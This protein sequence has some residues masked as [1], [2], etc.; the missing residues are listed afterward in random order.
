MSLTTLVKLYRNIINYLLCSS[1][2]QLSGLLKLL[3]VNFLYSD[4]PTKYHDTI[5]NIL[6]APV[7]DGYELGWEEMMQPVVKFLAQTGPFRAVEGISSFDEKFIFGTDEIFSIDQ[8]KKQFAD[9]L[10]RINGKRSQNGRASADFDE[11]LEDLAKEN[12]EEYSEWVSYEK[13]GELPFHQ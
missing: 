12:E 1:Q 8:F 5:S 9:L 13:S 3:E 2:I 11:D 6:A 7:F 10:T 4:I